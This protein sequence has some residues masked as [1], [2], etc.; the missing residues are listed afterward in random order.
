VLALAVAVFAPRRTLLQ[1][2][3][4][5]GSSRPEAQN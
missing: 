3:W 5:G 4:P 2:Q 1:A